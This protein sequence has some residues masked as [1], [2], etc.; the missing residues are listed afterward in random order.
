MKEISTSSFDTNE[1][2][3]EVVKAL[4]K[5]GVV[6]VPTDTVYGLAA[7]AR[8]E[9]AVDK[10]FRI[11]GRDRKKALPV[12]V[13]SFDMLNDIV[14]I[15]DERVG[16]F[17]KEVWPG[18]VTCVLLLR[19][20]I[21]GYICGGEKETI[22]VRMPD[23]DLVQKIIDDFG[24]PIT[25]TSANLTGMPENTEIEKL[26]LELGNMKYRPDLIL[27][28]GTLPPSE[29]STIVDCTTW[30]P[31]ILREGAIASEDLKEIF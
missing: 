25:G 29:P 27:N 21:K 7:D 11:K 30:P 20:D 24:G 26:I 10:V 2:V 22:A 14:H 1:I 31:K 5:G 9:K 16:N 19:K 13:S 8:N 15:E 18:K 6:V 17:L 23:Y 4:K 12:F 3:F 28:A